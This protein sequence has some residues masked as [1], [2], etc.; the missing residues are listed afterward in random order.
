[1]TTTRQYKV[2]RLLQKELGDYFQKH[3][4]EMTG[5]KMV[6]VTVVRI[7]P[8]LGVAR[9]YLSIFPSQE[10]EESVKSISEK[11]L[12]VRSEMGKRLR[13]QLRHIPEFAFFPDDSLDY[14]D[15]IENLLND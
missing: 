8:D 11:A 6:S 14:I 2:S 10:M 13:N 4:S 3:G 12:M 1:M 7:S 15:N 9:V 5:G